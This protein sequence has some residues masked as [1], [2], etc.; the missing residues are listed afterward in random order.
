MSKTLRCLMRSFIS[1]ASLTF[2]AISAFADIIPDDFMFRVWPY[3]YK[4]DGTF[5]VPAASDASLG[6]V[7]AS[8]LPDVYFN[9]NFGVS[10]T[11]VGA[12]YYPSVDP[13]K[14]GALTN[15]VKSQYFTLQAVDGSG[16]YSLV[17]VCPVVRTY[18]SVVSRLVYLGYSGDG[19][20][21][22]TTNSSGYVSFNCIP[23]RVF[24]DVVGSTNTV[25]RRVLLDM[26]AQIGSSVQNIDVNVSGLQSAIQQGNDDIV[27]ALIGDYPELEE[28]LKKGNSRAVDVRTSIKSQLQ[29][30]RNEAKKQLQD[31]KTDLQQDL[32]DWKTSDQTGYLNVR[33]AVNDVTA[34]VDSLKNQ[35]STFDPRTGT[36]IP[37]T[38][39][40]TNY[41]VV[42]ITNVVQQGASQISSNISSSVDTLDSHARS[43]YDDFMNYAVGNSG[44]GLRVHIVSPTEV[45]PGPDVLVRDEAVLAA[46]EDGVTFVSPDITHISDAWDSFLAAYSK[47]NSLDW[48]PWLERWVPF[49]E[50]V[51]NYYAEFNSSVPASDIAADF[52]ER[53]FDSERYSALPWFE[54][55]EVLL[56]MIADVRSNS[57]GVADIQA[58]MEAQVV[59]FEG[60]S[61]NVVA[62]SGDVVG[63]FQYV[64]RFSSSLHSVFVDRAAPLTGEY[65]LLS[66]GH[67]IGDTPL[68]L[69]INPDIQD[70]CRLIMQC[71]W[72]LALLVFLW[73]IVNWCWS[74]VVA[75]LRWLWSM[76]DV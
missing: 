10:M 16:Y 70:L 24:A 55:V 71:I 58:E 28:E 42:P 12:L 11:S 18:A 4:A 17:K 20:T 25:Y 63:L 26:L 65:V 31:W 72:F 2:F 45:N 8:A 67:W 53:G 54:R 22:I 30:W 35:F 33:Q 9:L 51:T 60:L 44:S 37:Y 48:T 62:A 73:S 19:V 14:G 52:I 56:A 13:V 5:N 21:T 7:S 3:R 36:N 61:T 50:I 76:F 74:K 57:V 15:S 66:S 68:V 59:N 49:S 38:A 40:T 1:L 6:T 64:E 41:V 46:L 23:S 47:T 32:Q 43:R 27:D 75:V 39:F 69:R 29:A 34:A